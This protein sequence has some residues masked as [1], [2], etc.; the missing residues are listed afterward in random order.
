MKSLRTWAPVFA[1]ML[2]IFLMSAAPGETSGEQSGRLLALLLSAFEWLT[3]VS[4]SPDA[5]GTLEL[6]LRKGAHM[7]EYAVLFLLSRR[8]FS[9]SGSRRPDLHALLLCAAYAAGDELHQCF[10][11]DRGPSPVDVMIDTAGA[12]FAL[13]ARRLVHPLFRRRETHQNA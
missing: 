13:L 1:W 8:A 5:L 4:P 2:L 9:Q 7:A 12:L 6:L 10:V 3:G 11:P